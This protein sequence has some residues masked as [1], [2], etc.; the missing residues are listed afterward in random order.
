MRE[1][2]TSPANR[3]NDATYV[4]CPPLIP[5][6]SSRAKDVLFPNEESS[7]TSGRVR[8]ATESTKERSIQAQ[9]GF[10]VPKVRRII[11]QSEA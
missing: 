7:V 10:I 6:I 9:E 8:H 5:L 3:I 2:K 1:R 4:F 11:L